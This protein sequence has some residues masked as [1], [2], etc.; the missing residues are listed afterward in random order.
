MDHIITADSPPPSPSSLDTPPVQPAYAKLKSAH[1]TDFYM[2][3]LNITI[4]RRSSSNNDSEI[5]I[6]LTTKNVSHQHAIIRY[7]FT[8]GIA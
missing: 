2:R 8:S 6:D 3:K 7:N 1:F 5:D 4:G